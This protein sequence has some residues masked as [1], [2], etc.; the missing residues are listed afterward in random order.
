MNKLSEFVS[1]QIRGGANPNELKAHLV[2]NGWK[3]S[4]VNIAINEVLGKRRRSRLLFGLLG[5]VLVGIL[6]LVL[7]SIA[8]N[9]SEGETPKQNNPTGG[10]ETLKTEIPSET[11]ASKEDS[12]EKDE[13]YK[14]ILKSGF[15]CGSL[16]SGVE[17]TYCI[18]AYEE[19]YIVGVEKI[20]EG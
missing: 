17:Q 16:P 10:L 9:A 19:L 8:K 7:I 4:D 20:D 18:R 6:A 11:C 14:T 5:I 15:E 12:I 3:E 1:E 13:C 2:G